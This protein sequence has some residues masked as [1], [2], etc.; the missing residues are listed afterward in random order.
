[1]FSDADR[2]P[3]ALGVNLTEIVQLL[4]VATLVPQLF[5]SLKSPASVPVTAMLV[6]DNIAVPVFER[7]MLFVALLVPRFSFPKDKLV[8]ESVATGARLVSVNVADRLPAVAIT[9]K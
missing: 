1:M 2:A 5:V 4:P 9:A 8:A 6:I 7:V 3:A